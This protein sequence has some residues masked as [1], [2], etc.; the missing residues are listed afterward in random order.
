MRSPL[1][2]GLTKGNDGASCFVVVMEAG[3]REEE[4]GALG[5]W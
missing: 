5:G 4:A 3:G 1:L 2:A